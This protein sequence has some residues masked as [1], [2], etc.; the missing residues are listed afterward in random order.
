MPFK[1]KAMP[2][3]KLFITREFHLYFRSHK[4]DLHHFVGLSAF[5]KVFVFFRHSA[6]QTIQITRPDF[7][8]VCC[9]FILYYIHILKII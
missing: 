6:I 2:A 1:L 8:P 7:S 9:Y 5:H 4:V 3:T